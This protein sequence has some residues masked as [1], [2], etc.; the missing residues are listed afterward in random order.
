MGIYYNFENRT[1]KYKWDLKKP[2][3][4]SGKVTESGL[5]SSHFSVVEQPLLAVLLRERPK[6][7]VESSSSGTLSACSSPQSS[8]D[9]SWPAASL[10]RPRRSQTA[11][12]RF[13]EQ[14]LCT[15]KLQV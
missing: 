12:E 5:S 9:G 2:R 3:P 4:T 15:K 11:E 1:T 14:F 8:S 13:S 6:A 10:A 7:T